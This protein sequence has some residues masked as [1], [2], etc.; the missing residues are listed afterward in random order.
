MPE[1]RTL[2]S[3]RSVVLERPDLYS[4]LSAGQIPNP[5]LAPILVLIDGGAP[6][7]DPTQGLFRARDNF[8]GLVHLASLCLVQPRLVLNPAERKE[9]DLEPRDVPLRDLYYISS[10]FQG[11][12]APEPATKQSGDDIG[13]AVGAVS[14]GTD[15]PHPTE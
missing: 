13:S 1:T 8:R 3:G 15:L 5:L 10:Y 7:L 6:V 4:A 9:G 2:P 14:D 11:Y 12:D